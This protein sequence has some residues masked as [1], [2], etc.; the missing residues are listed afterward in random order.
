MTARHP[1]R[2]ATRDD[3]EA[4][5]AMYQK[6]WPIHWE[7][8]EAVLF[9][10]DILEPIGGQ[11]LVAVDDQRVVG[12][13]EFIPIH[14]PARYGFWGYLEALE[15]DRE[16]YR[17]GIG[18]ALV[19]E[20]VR[21]CKALGCQ[22]FGTS[23]DDERSE[24][25]YRK[26][27]MTNVDRSLTT[28]FAL[29]ADGPQVEVDA[30]EELAPSERPWESFLHVLGRSHCASYWWSM[31][32]RRKEAGQANARDAF[33]ERIRRGEESAVVFYTGSWLHVF[34]PPN[35]AKDPALLQAAVAHGAT[36]LRI[37]HK[38]AFHTLMPLDLADAVR[39]VPG[40]YPTES[41]Y[42]FHMWMPL[43]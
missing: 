31:T 29:A 25:L 34:V 26:C 39:A 40:I 32:F 19:K 37:V 28:H 7:T 24:G 8:P 27:G 10:F 1:V 3:A 42:H 14:E 30:T 21:R 6:T 16:R 18:T 5:A 43:E 9:Q 11:V 36:R 17:R 13:A 20:A 23:P 38:E 15:V 41:H 35:R 2:E 33:A 22:R 12:H 4:I